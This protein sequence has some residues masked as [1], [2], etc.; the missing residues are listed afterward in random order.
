MHYLPYN[1]GLGDV[2]RG[3]LAAQLEEASEIDERVLIFTHVEVV[4]TRKEQKT[5]LFDHEKV[6]K[7]LEKHKGVVHTIFTGHRH[8]GS[9][10]F[11]EQLN[12]HC[13][14]ILCP[15]IVPEGIACHAVCHIHP[16][17]RIDVEGFGEVSSMSLL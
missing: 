4:R 13:Y 11:N 5:L 16:D 6:T 10:H 1:G 8:E 15:L 14:S 9:Y 2:Q 12:L 3:W 7:L 17:G